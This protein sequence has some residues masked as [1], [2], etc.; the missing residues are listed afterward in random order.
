M[1]FADAIDLAGWI[2]A[3]SLAMA[4]IF[5]FVIDYTGTRFTQKQQDRD[6]AFTEMGVVLTHARDDIAKLELRVDRLMEQ[7]KDCERRA[8]HFER[9]LIRKGIDIPPYDPAAG[10]GPHRPLAQEEE[11]PS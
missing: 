2:T 6:K 7:N 1:L 8:A 3:G 5:K 10:S 9:E 4:G 11:G